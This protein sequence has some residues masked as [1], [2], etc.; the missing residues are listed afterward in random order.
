M[1]SLGSLHCYFIFLCRL[2]SLYYREAE[3]FFSKRKKF[4][5]CIPDIYQKESFKKNGTIMHLRF[6]F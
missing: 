3:I 2:D 4:V 5:T 6:L 1:N